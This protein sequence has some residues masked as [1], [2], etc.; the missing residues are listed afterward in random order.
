MNKT[1][2]SRA[3]K[4]KEAF[5]L[6]EKGVTEITDSETFKEFMRFSSKFHHYSFRN[7]L[8]IWI[9][10]PQA[11]FV[12][13]FETWKKLGRFVK[14]GESGIMILAPIRIT[15]KGENELGKEENEEY[16]LFRPIYVFD[17]SQTQG[18]TI[19]TISDYVKTLEGETELYE[20]IRTISPFK[21]TETEDC[22]GADGNYRLKEKDIF[23][24]SLNPTKNRLLTLIH[25]IGHGLLHADRN[26]VPDKRVREIEAECVGYITCHALGID[27]SANSFGYLASYGKLQTTRLIENS[28]ERINRAVHKILG[29]FEDKYM[30]QAAEN[31]A[32]V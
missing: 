21:V 15:K 22:N 6:V 17:I 20:K 26:D 13:G 16:T 18:E 19:P 1:K 11:T 28:R 32:V 29:D 23:I 5:E 8:L 3:E 9:Q 12:A 24:N 31:G 10:K 4:V 30:N 2:S 27:T 7:Q 25:E 14:K